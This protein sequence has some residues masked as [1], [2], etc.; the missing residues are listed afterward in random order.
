MTSKLIVECTRKDGTKL[1]A[2][3][4][5]PRYYEFHQ[6]PPDSEQWWRFNRTEKTKSWA[7]ILV[8]I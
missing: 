2:I 7:V 8:D 6:Q 1:R 4:T 3:R 5:R